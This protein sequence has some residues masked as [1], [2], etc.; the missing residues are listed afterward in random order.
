MDW[1]RP[2]GHSPQRRPSGSESNTAPRPSSGLG[3]RRTVFPVHLPRSFPFFQ[4][5]TCSLGFGSPAGSPPAPLSTASPEGS[6]GQ[7]PSI[8]EPGRAPARPAG[9]PS[10]RL[11]RARTDPRADLELSLSLDGT[12]RRAMPI[13]TQHCPVEIKLLITHI[14]DDLELLIPQAG[15]HHDIS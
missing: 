3:L 1:S 2:P 13:P 10:G 6:S 11:W 7:C 8:Q 12:R 4:R 9:N 14:L 15:V 5:T